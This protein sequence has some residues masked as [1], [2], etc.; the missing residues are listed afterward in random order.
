[1]KTVLALLDD[2]N[3]FFMICLRFLYGFTR[4][5]AREGLGFT[6]CRRAHGIEV[7]TSIEL[8]YHRFHAFFMKRIAQ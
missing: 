1:M 2:V 5:L 6:T 4:I 7:M 3:K 8:I